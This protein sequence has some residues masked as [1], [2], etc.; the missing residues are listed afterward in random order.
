MHLVQS[1]C[2]IVE[3]MPSSKSCLPVLD[4]VESEC[5]LLQ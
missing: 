4:H 1:A 5:K 3:A 2:R